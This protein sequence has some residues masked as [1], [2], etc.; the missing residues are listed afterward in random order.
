ML[1]PTNYETDL[2]EFIKFLVRM[3]P[4]SYV[5][6]LYNSDVNPCHTV[7]RYA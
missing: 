7:P 5:Y 4:V 1:E 2:S 6:N 3:E